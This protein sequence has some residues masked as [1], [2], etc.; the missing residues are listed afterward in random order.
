MDNFHGKPTIITDIDGTLFDHA[1]EEGY[2]FESKPTPGAVE[3]MKEWER[4]GYCIMVIS[5]RPEYE[6]WATMR[7]LNQWGMPWHKLVLGLGSGKRFLINDTK[8]HTKDTAQ[9][10]VVERDSG[11]EQV[12]I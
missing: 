9:A 6:Y 8:P 2:S 3:K 5:A 10:I 12:N 1:G 11:L 4:L 7:Q